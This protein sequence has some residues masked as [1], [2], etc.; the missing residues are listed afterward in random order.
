[1]SN[2]QETSCAH[3]GSGVDALPLL[4]IVNCTDAMQTASAIWTSHTDD[5]RAFG[6]AMTSLAKVYIRYPALSSAKSIK[7]LAGLAVDAFLNHD[8]VTSVAFCKLACFGRHIQSLGSAD[9]FFQQSLAVNTHLGVG[10]DVEISALSSA[11]QYN[12]MVAKVVAYD[13]A[14]DR[15]AVR[16]PNSDAIKVKAA[17]LIVKSEPPG[18]LTPWGTP[19]RFRLKAGEE[20]L[21]LLACEK[22]IRSLQINEMYLLCRLQEEVPCD[23]L[24][25]ENPCSPRFGEILDPAMPP[26]DIATRENAPKRFP[27]LADCARCR[28]PGGGGELK[29]CSR[30]RMVR[31]CSAACQR[32]DWPCHRARCPDPARIPAWW[33][34]MCSP[35]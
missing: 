4:Q 7:V 1:M 2:A 34:R 35:A 9:K 21:E 10:S 6:Q 11:T 12:G 30:C 25:V 8:Y 27:Y 26:P 29:R 33:G 13:A 22:A 31:Y 17:N 23:C 19:A 15:W 24:D 16:L 20:P 5:P 28:A 32:E 18:G 14:K 3:G